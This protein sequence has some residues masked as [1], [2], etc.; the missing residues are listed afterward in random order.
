[1]PVATEE[2]VMM[3][4]QAEAN[5]C[6]GDLLQPGQGNR[7]VTAWERPGHSSL[8]VPDQRNPILHASGQIGLRGW[9]RTCCVY[10][11]ISEA[12]CPGQLHSVFHHPSEFTTCYSFAVRHVEVQRG[13]L[14]K[15]GNQR[16]SGGYLPSCLQL[17]LPDRAG[18]RE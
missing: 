15:L 11:L 2:L 1:M 14:P 13:V 3:Q 8:L 18:S 12:V 17:L 10:L 5:P 16:T 6:F 7:W 9:A 4:V